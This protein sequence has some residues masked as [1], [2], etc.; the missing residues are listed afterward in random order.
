MSLRNWKGCCKSNSGRKSWSWAATFFLLSSGGCSIFLAALTKN[1]FDVEGYFPPDHGL[2]VDVVFWA[3][4][5]ENALLLGTFYV[6][7]RWGLPEEASDFLLLSVVLVVATIFCLLHVIQSGLIAV[8]A[9]P[10]VLHICAALFYF[11]RRHVI[12]SGFV[13]SMMQHS[14]H[15]LTVLLM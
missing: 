10:V 4:L 8:I 13:I 9:F 15:N 7:F 3:V 14:F 11:V 2:F 12:V 1:I 6:I 5:R